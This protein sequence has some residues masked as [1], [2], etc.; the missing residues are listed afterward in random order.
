MT[1]LR[2]SDE[3]ILHIAHPKPVSWTAILTTIAADLGVDLVPYSSW[4]SALE[5]AYPAGDTP[6]VDKLREN[7][8]LRLIDHFRTIEVGYGREPLGGVKMD[9]SKALREAS[10]LDMPQMT[11]EWAHR[12]MFAWKK[13]G[14]LPDRVV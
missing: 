11:S 2:N 12:W 14:F 8:A 13:C 6:D 1:Q 5:R 9:V 7:P 4:L 3:P 10:A